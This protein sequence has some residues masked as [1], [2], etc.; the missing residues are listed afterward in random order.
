MHA[1][2]IAATSRSFWSEVS[3]SVRKDGEVIID[4]RAAALNRAD[5]LQREG[6]TPSRRAGPSGWAWK[7]PGWCEAGAGSAGK[8]ATGSARCGHRRVRRAGGRARWHGAA[9]PEGLDFVEAAAIRKRSPPPTQPCSRRHAGGRHV[10]IQAG[11]AGWGWPP[12]SWPNASVPR[13]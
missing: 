8:L 3:R 12:S 1:I 7:W 2:L 9:L 13:W 6:T 11:A 5:L 4:I 10:F